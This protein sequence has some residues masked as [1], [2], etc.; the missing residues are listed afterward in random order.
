MRTAQLRCD[1]LCLESSSSERLW[2][3]RSH[4]I[5]RQRVTSIVSCKRQSGEDENSM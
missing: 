4:T 2:T 1:E 5:I 3:P